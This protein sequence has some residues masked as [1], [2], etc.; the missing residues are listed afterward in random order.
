M[1][2]TSGDTVAVTVNDTQSGVNGAQNYLDFTGGSGGTWNTHQ[3]VTVTG[4]QDV[5]TTSEANVTLTHAVSVQ[6]GTSA[7]YTG[8]ADVTL[9]VDVT[10]DDAPNS[11]PAFT[12]GT[13]TRSVAENAAGGT[14]VG[15]AIPAATDRDGDALTY[16]LGGADADS[17][18]FDGATRQITTRE[19][20]T[21]DN[22]VKSVYRVTV[23]AADNNGGRATV[24]VTLTV[25]DAEE[26]VASFGSATSSAGE[27]GGTQNVQVNLSPS[28]QVGM[29]LG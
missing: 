25:R 15:A 8:L 24:R 17:F 26:P 4:V 16:T 5:D 13:L 19:G 9:N 18:Q 14:N 10:D 21:Y 12:S 11:A 20:V 7:P 2:I 1:S 3:A 27:D 23:T 22:E 6:A 28:P 29:T